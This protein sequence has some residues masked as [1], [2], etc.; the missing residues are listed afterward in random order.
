[1]FNFLS[2]F[3]YLHL[4]KYV[5][6]GSDTTAPSGG[7]GGVDRGSLA[8]CKEHEDCPNDTEFCNGDDLCVTLTETSGLQGWVIATIIIAIFLLVSY[9]GLD[10]KGQMDIH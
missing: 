4:L 1:M 7:G 9:E 6:E 2:V 3:F 8:A 5:V 10:H